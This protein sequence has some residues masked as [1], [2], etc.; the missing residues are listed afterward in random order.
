[1]HGRDGG[2]EW[3]LVVCDLPGGERAYGRIVDPEL[4]RSAEVD[5]LVG[6]KLSLTPTEMDTA[7]GR[8]LVNVATR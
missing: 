6:A 7:M 4:L 3:G 5:E 8:Q 2:P 1:V